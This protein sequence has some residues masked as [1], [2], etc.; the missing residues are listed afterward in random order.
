MTI[1]EVA[2]KVT[3]EEG[4]R[5]S[6]SIAQVRECLKILNALTGGELYKLLRRLP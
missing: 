6:I 1:N 2:V 5:V 4:K 3:K